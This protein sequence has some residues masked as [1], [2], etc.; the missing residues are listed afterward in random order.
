MLEA[1]Y[2]AAGTGE[3]WTV[4]AGTAR[5]AGA[6]AAAGTSPAVAALVSGGFEIAWQATAGRELF[7]LAGGG[8]AS[9][10]G[11]A[12]GVHDSPVMAVLPPTPTRTTV[13]PVIGAPDAFARTELAVAGL[14]VGQV[15]ADNTCRA[16]AGIVTGQDP[17]AGGRVV[18]GTP[19][20]LAESTGKTPQGTPCHPVVP[21]LFGSSDSAARTFLAGLGLVVGQVGQGSDCD[22]FKGDVF[23]QS[24][25][26]GTMVTPGT[27]VDLTEA[28]GLDRN[29][30]PC[31]VD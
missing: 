29:N 1:V 7:T 23:H 5:D 22:V 12:L 17:G 28:T 3:L 31:N 10:A 24:I 19:V 25:A 13:P 30:K 6:A 27:A 16:D 8:P 9:D 2:Q 21:N 15:T 4:N 18:P 11:F 14:T 20:T 26:A